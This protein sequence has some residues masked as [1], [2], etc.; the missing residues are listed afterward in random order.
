MSHDHSRCGPSFYIEHG[1]KYCLADQPIR[2]AT[3]RERL[4]SRWLAW[5]RRREL[6]HIAHVIIARKRARI[7]S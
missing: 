5:R 2:T 6:R 1:V 7:S 4:H 3:R